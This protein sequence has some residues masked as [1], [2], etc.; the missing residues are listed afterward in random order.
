MT[1]LYIGSVTATV[2]WS[3]INFLLLR[4]LDIDPPIEWW[5]STVIVIISNAISNA[6]ICFG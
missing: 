2:V 5:V 3:A 1:A 4:G 6:V